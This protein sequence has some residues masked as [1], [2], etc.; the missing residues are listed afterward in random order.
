MSSRIGDLIAA[1]HGETVPLE[2]MGLK[3]HFR[4]REGEAER[5]FLESERSRGATFIY[6]PRGAGKPTLMRLMGE[7]VREVGGFEE[8]FS[9]LTVFPSQALY[10]QRRTPALR[11]AASQ[12]PSRLHMR[13]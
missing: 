7:E 10:G 6:G 9:T 8:V 11:H 2:I 3:A 12:H 4:D 13:S 1:I 5:I